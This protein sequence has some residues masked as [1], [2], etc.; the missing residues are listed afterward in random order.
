MNTTELTQLICNMETK[1]G[2][3]V[4]AI[5]AALRYADPDNRKRLLNAFPDL[6]QKYG[7]N[8]MFAVAQ[9]M[10]EQLVTKQQ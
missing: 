5:G 6:V 2:S 4:G 9:T 1:G 3:F 7:P 8:G 10:A